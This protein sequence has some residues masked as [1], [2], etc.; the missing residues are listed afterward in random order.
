MLA[1]DWLELW[2]AWLV[3][4]SAVFNEVPANPG[5]LYDTASVHG[6]CLLA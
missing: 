6:L 3:G 4:V 1:R 2:L 5:P